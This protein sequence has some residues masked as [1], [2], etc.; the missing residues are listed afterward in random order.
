MRLFMFLFSI[1]LLQHA[2]A[3]ASEL[4]IYG[5][6]STFV[7]CVRAF[8]SESDSSSN[9]GV[10]QSALMNGHSVLSGQ[11]LDGQYWQ[12][13]DCLTPTN[14]GVDNTV[15]AQTS[16]CPELRINLGDREVYV[17]PSV[18]GKVFSLGRSSW[19]C[20]GGQWT[21]DTGGG[22]G[23][24]SD[25]VPEKFES[26]SSSNFKVDNCT[27]PLPSRL[28]GASISAVSMLS[29]SIDGVF[30]S[31]RAPF[32]CNDGKWT[33][34][35]PDVECRPSYCNESQRVSWNSPDSL[36]QC[37]GMIHS[38]GSVVHEP[39][40]EIYFSSLA[41]AL[42][43]TKSMVGHAEFSCTHS[44]WKPIV[45]S[46]AQKGPNELACKERTTAIGTKEYSCI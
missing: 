18:S 12:Y 9:Q 34:S 35:E 39:S 5:F 33:V 37:S 25:P 4:R 13:M 15:L 42:R 28:H 1:L 19:V 45:T 40:V 11:K 21:R 10:A 38:D 23:G 29:D 26:C 8:E 24:V 32:V 20:Q 31:G 14:S 2:Q 16:S 27:F 6:T 22:E 46:C 44:G 17:P 43:M 3:G 7:D 36:T 30:Y 41:E